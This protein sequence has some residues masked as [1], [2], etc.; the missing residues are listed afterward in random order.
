MPTN[1]G[2]NTPPL[3]QGQLI[4]GRSQRQN[5]QG[6]SYSKEQ[7]ASPNT[8]RGVLEMDGD[9]DCGTGA[10]NGRHKFTAC[11]TYVQR[12]GDAE[13]IVRDAVDGSTSNLVHSSRH[14]REIWQIL[15]LHQGAGMIIISQW[16]VKHPSVRQRL[17]NGWQLSEEFCLRYTP[18]IGIRTR[19]LGK[20]GR[21]IRARSRVQRVH[22][23]SRGMPNVPTWL[24][25]WQTKK[26]TEETLMTIAKGQCKDTQTFTS[27]HM[28]SLLELDWTDA[29]W[30]DHQ[31]CQVIKQGR[32]A[33]LLPADI[34]QNG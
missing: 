16:L 20:Q 6:R 18:Q 8:A 19:V 27:S 10:S 28:N 13:G 2:N 15:G 25:G 17:R 9:R 22:V 11:T 23:L 21:Q 5:Y 33:G 31:G 30:N 4:L 1:S 32:R 14:L 29:W 24:T 7:M 34:T 12:N 3:G 26:G